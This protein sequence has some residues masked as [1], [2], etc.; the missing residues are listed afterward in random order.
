MKVF[1]IQTE[2]WVF[3]QGF[4]EPGAIEVRIEDWSHFGKNNLRW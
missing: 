2:A 3:T 1:W 4:L